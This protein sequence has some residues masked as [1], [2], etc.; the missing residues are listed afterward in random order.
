M[1]AQSAAPKRGISVREFARR[2]GVDESH[3]RQMIKS[4]HIQK[5]SDGT[6]D[7]ALV[8]GD[9][10]KVNRHRPKGADQSAD[11]VR[12]IRKN[13]APGPHLES[14]PAIRTTPLSGREAAR[15]EEADEDRPGLADTDEF[16]A[17]IRAGRIFKLTDSERVKEGA[18]ALKQVLAA[19]Q[20]AGD[21][22]ELS[23]AEEVFFETARAA[24]DAW[25]N[26]PVR[27]GPLVAAELGLEADRVT[28]V[29]TEHVHS[30]LADLGE[31]EA[32]FASRT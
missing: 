8:G 24:R 3:I 27:V 6:L 21:L 31:P 23:L 25:M 15:S 4:Q 7:P 5:F 9:W 10:R 16:V 28:A 32:D 14:A 2:E 20:A 22:I 29:L 26:W 11:Q 12:T 19:R 1:S 18:L 30:H 13:S 17:G